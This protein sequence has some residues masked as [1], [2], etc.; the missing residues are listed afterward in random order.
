ML[1]GGE[2]HGVEAV[3]LRYFW[4]VREWCHGVEST[5]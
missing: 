1:D 5:G 4:L 3:R 2:I